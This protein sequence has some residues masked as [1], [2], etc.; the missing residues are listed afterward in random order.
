MQVIFKRGLIRK[1]G[2]EFHGDE[3]EVDKM[4]KLDEKL[5]EMYPLKKDEI[6][7]KKL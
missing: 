7:K 5:T 2:W 1:V 3:T 4:R 6:K